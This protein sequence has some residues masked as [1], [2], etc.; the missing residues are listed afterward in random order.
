MGQLANEMVNNFIF[1]RIL[2][3]DL[4]PRH[5][6][7]QTLENLHF[8]LEY[9]PS[10]HYCEK[11]WVINRIVDEEQ[12]KAVINLLES[13]QQKYIHIPFIKEEYSSIGFDFQCFSQPDYFHSEEY[14]RLSPEMQARAIDRTYHHKILYAMN[15]NGSKNAA[16]REGRSLAK[17]VMPWDGNCF[18]TERAWQEILEK[19]EACEQKPYLLVPMTRALDNRNLLKQNFEP[20]PVEE[21]QIIFHQKAREEFNEMVR[22]GHFNKIELLWRLGVPGYW[23]KWQWDPWDNL[24]RQE[25]PEAGQFMFVGW[26]ARLFSGV[27][28]CE[29][30][31]YSR[32]KKR[33]QGIRDFLDNLDAQLSG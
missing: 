21:P 27:Q 6:Q 7:G 20:N 25:S 32:A 5:K 10:L 9:E 12:E 13:Y 17:W 28:E 4:P 33:R 16:L 14:Q 18:L 11:R 23:D 26:V 2:G 19:V 22:Y 8:I 3:N 24:D 30:N 29:Q 15:I 1:Y 31:S